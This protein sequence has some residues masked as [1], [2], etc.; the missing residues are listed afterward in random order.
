[1]YAIVGRLARILVTAVIGLGLGFVVAASV[2]ADGPWDERGLTIGGVLLAYALAGTALGFR[3][4][5]W[6]GLGLTLPGLAALAFYTATG[7][8]RWWYLPY[9]ALIAA[10]AVGGA[11]GAAVGPARR[12]PAGGTAA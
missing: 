10:L 3:A 11:H 1:M 9:A 12:R 8:G 6:Y 7:E 5:A 2:F 4:S